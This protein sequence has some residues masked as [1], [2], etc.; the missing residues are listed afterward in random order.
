MLVGYG[1]YRHRGIVP[2]TRSFRIWLLLRNKW[3]RMVTPFRFIFLTSS[4]PEV[5]GSQGSAMDIM[6]CFT[7][8]I[9]SLVN[10]RIVPPDVHMVRFIVK[11]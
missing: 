1:H 10:S 8:S 5:G 4:A 3:N 7:Q 2:V 11:K 9:N 6:E